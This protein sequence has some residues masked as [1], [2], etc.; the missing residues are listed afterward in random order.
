MRAFLVAYA[1]RVDKK[2]RKLMRLLTGL[3]DDEEEEDDDEDAGDYQR[4]EGEN[5]EGEDTGWDGD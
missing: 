2:G 1:R 5:L 3:D 4:D